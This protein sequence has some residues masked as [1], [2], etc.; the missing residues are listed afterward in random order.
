[1][2]RRTSRAAETPLSGAPSQQEQHA[3]R[4]LLVVVDLTTDVAHHPV[5]GL[6]LAEGA[7]LRRLDL[8]D[9]GDRPLE[10]ELPR[11]V[12]A[13]VRPGHDGEIVEVRGRPKPPAAHRNRRPRRRPRAGTRAGM[14]TRSWSSRASEKARARSIAGVV[15]EKVP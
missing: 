7:V 4:H 8:D 14:Q 3:A 1:M 11:L 6:D 9:P 12:R 5:A 10:L 2:A 15:I 13:G